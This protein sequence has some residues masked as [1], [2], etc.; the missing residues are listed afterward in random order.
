MQKNETVRQINA[1]AM[2]DGVSLG[3]FGI[4]SLA[5]FRGSFA[6]PFLSTLFSVMVFAAPFLAAALT[7]RFR[8]VAAGK[9]GNFTFASGFLHA[10]F[11]GLYATL[12][13]SLCVYVYLHYFDHGAIFAEYARALETPE[14]QV[15]LQQT[16][17]K[18][19]LD[20]ISGGRGAQGLADAMR[21]IGAATYA[22]V[23]IYF[24]VIF[25][26]LISAL[27]GAAARRSGEKGGAA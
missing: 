1:Y 13:V 16:G 26:P 27:I 2:Q 21:A 19:E 9:G 4:L 8:N 11:T 14:S 7:F 6:Q 5:A 24:A 25:G 15:Y 20:M 23:P 22:V 17:L 18:D 3:L 10:L 12:W